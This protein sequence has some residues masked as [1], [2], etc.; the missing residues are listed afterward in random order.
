MYECLQALKMIKGFNGLRAIAALLVVFTHLEWLEPLQGTG[1]VPMLT[2]GTGV[3]LFFV[4][5]G[6]LITYL[7]IT[8]AAKTGRINIKY[9]FI[10]RAL[11]ILPLYFIVI[12]SVSLIHFFL[13]P[14][15]SIKGLF[16]AIAYIYNFVPVWW[17]SGLLGHLW[18]LAVE[19][20]FYLIWPILFSAMWFK[21]QKRLIRLLIAIMVIS[22]SFPVLLSHVYFL[23]TN[24]FIS[25]WTPCVAFNLLLG[26]ITAIILHP[27]NMDLFIKKLFELK[28]SIILFVLLWS[29]S[30]WINLPELLST[31]LRGV[32]FAQLIGWCYVHQN[33]ILVRLL[34]VKPLKYLGKISYGIY[35]YQGV[36]LS[37]SA[38]RLK[39]QLWPLPTAYAL[40][41]LIIITPLSYHYLECKL[42]AYGKKYQE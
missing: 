6:F 18:S 33:S 41:I 10:R 19:E 21:Y 34:D 13:W 29:H 37:T 14:S 28:L 27:K 40:M 4:L 7:L 20:H 23:K 11:R 24:F 42:I 2:G 31:I 9:F 36:L 26:C 5:S 8:E 25:R 17:Y 22:M 39:G 15:T 35:M 3:Q 16:F 1:L 32:A 38:G 30:L 12:I